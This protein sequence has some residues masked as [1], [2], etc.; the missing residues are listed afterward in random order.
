MSLALAYRK[1]DRL[2][3]H[4]RLAWPEDGADLCVCEI[5]GERAPVSFSPARVA[6]GVV[7]RL[8]LRDLDLHHGTIKGRPVLLDAMPAGSVML[9]DLRDRP[10]ISVTAATHG[11]I[12]VLSGAWAWPSIP[13]TEMVRDDPV[14]HHLALCIL[15]EL[16][17]GRA[18]SSPMAHHIAQA[19][20]AHLM[21]RYGQGG[22]PEPVR[23]GLAGWQIRRAQDLLAS[24]LMRPRQLTHIARECGLSLSH[25]S[26]SFRQ[27]VGDTPHGWLM[28]RR[29]E[30]AQAMLRD[31]SKPLADIAVTCGFSDQSHFTRLFTREIGVSPGAWRRA[32]AARPIARSGRHTDRH[33]AM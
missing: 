10:E 28:R 1:I 12:F 31:G 26:R 13:Q 2:P 30:S 9:H 16:A 22:E 25:F 17:E 4:G 14:V 27:S 20:V 18:A 15:P 5:L 24:D 23:G 3:P 21:A 11:V 29:L 8:Q 32:T 19:L 33:M 6:K 7:V